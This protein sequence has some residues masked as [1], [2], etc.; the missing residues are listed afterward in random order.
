[1][2]VKQFPIIDVYQRVIKI[3]KKSHLVTL[4]KNNFVTSEVKMHTLIFQYRLKT[5]FHVMYKTK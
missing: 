4:K 1:M 2:A 5:N 3:N